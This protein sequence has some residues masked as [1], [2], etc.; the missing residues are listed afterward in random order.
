[1]AG[2]FSNWIHL[3]VNIIIRSSTNYVKTATRLKE[4]SGQ[5]QFARCTFCRYYISKGELLARTDE[6]T[7]TKD[8]A[9]NYYAFFGISTAYFSFS[10]SSSSNIYL[11]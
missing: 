4:I 11:S 8:A 1:M 3:S 10:I 7:G 2:H 5:T 9:E 6:Y